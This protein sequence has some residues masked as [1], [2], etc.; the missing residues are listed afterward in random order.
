MTSA[1][2]ILCHHQYAALSAQLA[3]NPSH[4]RCIFFA[5]PV[6]ALSTSWPSVPSVRLRMPSPELSSLMVLTMLPSSSSISHGSTR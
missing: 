2:Q 6:T 4:R 1:G 5:M 3:L